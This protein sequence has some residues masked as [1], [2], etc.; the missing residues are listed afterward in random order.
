MAIKIVGIAGSPR[1]GGN[2]ET[3][4]DA[5]LSSAAEA[6]AETSKISVRDVEFTPCVGCGGCEKKGV[7]VFKDDMPA[8]ISEVMEAD[9]VIL[10]APMYFMNVPGKTKSFIDRFQTQWSKKYVLKEPLRNDDRKRKGLV[11]GVGGTGVKDLFDGFNLMAKVY[12]HILEIEFDQEHSLYFKK[13]ENRGEIKDDEAAIAS[14][15][16][17]GRLLASG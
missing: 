9:V 10:A 15:V 13:V 3:L 5:V 1:K 17:L 4:L 12:F 2:T 14:A 11:I 7:C 6:G 16:N 8:I